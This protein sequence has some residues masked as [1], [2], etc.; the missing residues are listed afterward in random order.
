M[1][2]RDEQRAATELREA[3]IR[4]VTAAIAAA[5]MCWYLI[6]EHRRQAAAARLRHATAPGVVAVLEA[7]HKLAVRRAMTRELA[8]AGEDYALSERI[9]VARERWARS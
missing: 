8:G 9:R 4:L 6:P 7:A 2:S 5:I 1:S 3:Q